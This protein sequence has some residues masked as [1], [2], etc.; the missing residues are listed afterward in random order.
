MA[1]P[2]AQTRDILSFG[3][4]RLVASERLL[5]KD[6]T[7]VE[8]GARAL[9]ILIALVSRPNKIVSKKALLSRVWPDVT[10]EVASLRFHVANLRKVLGD[11]RN[12]TRHITT[13]PAEVVGY[14][15]TEFAVK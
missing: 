3:P 6:G 8:L 11:G 4:F 5:T 1:R 7:Q 10:V 2:S 13:C 15:G 12:G 9:D 14:I